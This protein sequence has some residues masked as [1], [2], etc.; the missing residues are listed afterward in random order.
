[1]SHSRE[2]EA[3]LSDLQRAELLEE[4]GETIDAGLALAPH[5]YTDPSIFRFERDDI[6]RRTWQY[7]GHLSQVA[8]SGDYFTAEV[9][10][11]PLVVVRDAEEIRAFV[12]ICRHRSHIVAK[13]SGS[14]S[15]LQCAYHAWT[16]NLDGTLRAAPRCEREPNFDLS[17]Y[18]LLPMRVETWGPLIFVNPDLEAAPLSRQ[19]GELPRMLEGKGYNLDAFVPRAVRHYDTACNWKILV[20]NMI[21]CYHCAVAHPSFKKYYH[22]GPDKYSIERH[23][24]FCYQHGPLRDFDEAQ[25]LKSTWGDFELVY[26]W[27]NLLMIIAPISYVVAPMRPITLDS[28][29]LGFEAYFL[30]EVEEA[31]VQEYVDYYEEI[32]AEDADLVSAVQRGH[33]AGVL[34]Q[35]PLLLDSEEMLRHVQRLIHRALEQGADVVEAVR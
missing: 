5:W 25:A 22:V 12:N 31:V 6:F 24:Y 16:Y 8:S 17:N 26:L 14:R 30:P 32:L 33:D 18:P 21:E 11:V 29:V 19:L 28:S 35:G 9:G 7:V 15:T 13:D 23:E 3:P 2:Q 1:M 20:D 4:L 10:G 27:P 34:P